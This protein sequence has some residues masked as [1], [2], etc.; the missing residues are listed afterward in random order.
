M[1]PRI[2]LLIALATLAGCGGGSAPLPPAAVARQAL[3]ASLDAW[4]AGKTSSSL[5]EGEPAIEA[6]DFEWKAGKVL[7]DYTL[8]EEATGQGVQT[9]SASLTIQGEASPK[10][11]KYMILGLAP[12]R[13]FR[14][15]D[16]NRAMNMDNSPAP[17]KQ[18]RY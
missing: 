18:S 8:G 3:Q 17:I 5:I 7:S 10:E 11:V 4:K 12:T 1:R 9:L 15:E 16:Y 13:I 6:V 2:S 14:D